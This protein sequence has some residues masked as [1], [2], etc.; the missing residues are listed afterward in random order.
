MKT[1]RFIL[2]VT[3]LLTFQYGVANAAI[4]FVDSNSAGKSGGIAFTELDIGATTGEEG[5]FELLSCATQSDGSNFFTNAEPNWDDFNLGDCG[6]SNCT[7]GIFTKLAPEPN[8]VGNTCFWN[9]PTNAATGIVT[10]YSGVNGNV[11]IADFECNTGIGNV[12]TAPEVNAP[13]GSFIIRIYGA[14]GNFLDAANLPG[15]K[16]FGRSFGGGSQSSLFV[17]G[18]PFPD[19]GV[20]DEVSISY[21]LVD[22]A[23]RACAVSLIMDGAPRIAPIPTLNEW[24]FLAF[25][26]LAGAS[27]L[28]F[29]RRRS[30]TA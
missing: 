11:P 19:G 8:N 15:S 4:N 24:G 22:T 16:E 14:N 21:Q 29:I 27:G 10:R 28:W 6:G 12:A 1:I 3:F 23:W 9:D 26:V 20:A 25:A 2:A 5:E 18:E 13:E 17:Y 30:V 7:M